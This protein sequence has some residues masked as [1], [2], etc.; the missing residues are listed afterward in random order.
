MKPEFSRKDFAVLLLHNVDPSWEA[1]D[2]A[3]ASGAVQAMKDALKEEEHC[4]I[5]LPVDST[6]VSAF[7]KPFDPKQHIV[8]N[9]CEE[10]CGIPKSDVMVTRALEDLNF[11][12]TGSPP[13]VISMSWDKAAV[14]SL[15]QQNGIATPLWRVYSTPGAEDWG[16]FPAIVKPAFEHCSYGI[17][18]E[19][20]VLNAKE[21]AERI[22]FVLETFRQPALVEDFIDGREFHVTLWGNGR[23]EM[24]P[25][26]E[27]DFTALDCLRDRLCTYESKFMPGSMHY[28]KIELKVPA[29]LEAQEILQLEHT[30]IQAYQLIGCRDYARIDLRLRDGV[31]YVL[32]INPNPDISPDTSLAYA[33]EAAGLSYGNVG[34][35]LVHFAAGRHPVFGS[36]QYIPVP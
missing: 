2:L 9:W 5:E 10:L 29:L 1:S 24:L 12:Y 18:S 14:K 21:L 7:L 23:I 15:L 36:G 19:A 27:M 3:E 25:A 16:C 22:A 28:E 34:N 8:F 6:D 33:A 13:E 31:F 4:V 26:A 11:S 32:D 35:T 30:A 20:V 17:T